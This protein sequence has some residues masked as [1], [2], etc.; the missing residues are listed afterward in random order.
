ME[1]GQTASRYV[2]VWA[3]EAVNNAGEE[4]IAMA[5]AL[6]LVI[7]EE[8]AKRDGDGGIT[9]YPRRCPDRP[10]VSAGYVA[11]GGATRDSIR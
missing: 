11:D 10:I 5:R 2:S 4:A 1:K 8:L 7:E 3:R 9:D 6:L